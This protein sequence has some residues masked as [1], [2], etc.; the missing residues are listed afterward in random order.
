MLFCYEVLP[1]Q[2]AIMEGEVPTH[3]HPGSAAG[4]WTTS[5]PGHGEKKPLPSLPT[6]PPA[7]VWLSMFQ[8]SPAHPTPQNPFPSEGSAEGGAWKVVGRPAP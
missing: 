6:Q 2:P 7:M 8:T 4:A 1:S 5:L 3:Q